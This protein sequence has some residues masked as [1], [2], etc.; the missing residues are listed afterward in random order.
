MK[1]LGNLERHHFKVTSLRGLSC[2][3]LVCTGL[4]PVSA[5]AQVSTAD[6]PGTAEAPAASQDGQLQDIVVTA[7]RREQKLQDVPVAVTAFSGST[8]QASGV[9]T[10]KELAF[11]DPSLNVPQ[12]V[13]VYLPFLRG[14]GNPAGGNLGNES[15]VP[16]YID[17]LYYAR[18]S[19][20]YLAINSIDRVEVL[21]GPQ[22]TLFGRN[23]SGGAIQMFTK[24]PGRA[25]EV[26]ATLSFGNYDRRTGQLYVSAPITDTLGWNISVA[27]TDQRDGWGKSITTGRDIFKEKLFSARSKLVWEP[28][29]TTKVKI[30]GFYAYSK[31][32]IGMVNDR[33]SGTYAQSP[34]IPLPGYPA[35]PIRLPSLADVPG[36]NF[37]NTRNNLEQFARAE[38]GGGSIRIDQSLGF[39]DL[40]SITGFRITDEQIRLDADITAQNLLNG[41]LNSRESQFTQEFQL[42]SNSDSRIDW[43]LGAY[44]LRSQVKYNPISLYGDAFGTGIVEIRSRQVINSYSV[45][46]QATAPIGETTNLTLGL[47]YNIDDLNGSSPTYRDSKQFKKLTW[48]ATLDHH[49]TDDVMG[50]VSISRGYKSGA[51]KTFPL[52]SPPALPE[53]IDSYELGLKTELF[54]R[55]VRLNGALFWNDIK[56]PQVLAVD[57]QG[58]I[59]GIILT[60][61]QQAR[62]KGA[63][64]GID[65]LVAPGLTLRG[66]ATY[67]D[68]KYRS[69]INAPFYCLNGNTIA[70][71]STALGGGPCPVPADGAAGN[72]LPNVAK[73]T[74]NAGLNY[75]I[76]TSIGAWVADVGVAH[77]GRFAWNPDNFVFEKAVTLVNASLNFTPDSADWLTIGLWG[78]NLG[79]VKYY[80]IT[81]E[82]V[83][84]GGTAGFQAGA[85]APR[86]YGGSL[87]VKF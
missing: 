55:R 29:D 23:A 20:A 6:A 41:D 27:G 16:V 39:A 58:L 83:G 49:L 56:N 47:R 59:P 79:G 42:K 48:K 87:S 14:I 32:D 45:F 53:V 11:V 7:Q 26:N 33:H 70:G 5:L 35:P 31:G 15:S 61:A 21:K 85:A 8:L 78:K 18:L 51:Y 84:P 75:K 73:W 2:A 25:Q 3:L 19:T 63:E 24:D 34:A 80:S 40:V 65:A 86:T 1:H 71:P 38:G 10:I 77:T 36:D 12:V 67:L 64:I 54:D 76:D 72:R 62:I 74:F 37:Y 66:G 69:Y 17:D 46:G 81:Q 9:S 50:Y 52:D 44:Y 22:G 60:N 82:S 30:V 68:G 43:I 57:V 4:T 13:G 28:S